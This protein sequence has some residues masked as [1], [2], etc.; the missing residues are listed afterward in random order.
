M[1]HLKRLLPGHLS[2]TRDGSSPGHPA[3]YRHVIAY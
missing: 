1:F 2:G 3:G